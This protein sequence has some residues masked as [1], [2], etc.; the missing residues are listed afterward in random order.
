MSRS[1]E[2]ITREDL[3]TLATFS[4]RHRDEWFRHDK[5]TGAFEARFLCAALCQ[6]AALHYV[7]GTNGIKDFD[8]YEMYA[9][10][11]DVTIP[12][13]A[14]WCYD[15]GPSKFGREEDAKLHPEYEGR[16][17]DV[18][19]RALPVDVD[20]DPVEAVQEYLGN[21]ATTTARMLAERAVVILE[22]EELLGT[23]AWPVVAA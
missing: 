19:V 1:V 16:R 7:D 5:P 22:P 11:P 18:F 21:P 13:R 14:H 3:G 15:F 2:P 8:I 10:L 20:A 17:V 9:D 6:G 12:Y 4:K 23:V